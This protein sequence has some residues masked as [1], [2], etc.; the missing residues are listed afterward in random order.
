MEKV[1]HVRPTFHLEAGYPLS[2]HRTQLTNE[3]DG[4]TKLKGVWLFL[5]SDDVRGAFSYRCSNKALSLFLSLL[6][7]YCRYFDLCVKDR[8]WTG[9]RFYWQVVCVWLAD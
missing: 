7:S 2:K 4:Q 6:L 9:E 8:N 3:S 5:G 1:G